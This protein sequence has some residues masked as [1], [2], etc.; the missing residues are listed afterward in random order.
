[1]NTDA[2]EFTP[3]NSIAENVNFTATTEQD[4][5]K[6]RILIALICVMASQLL[7]FQHR[8]EQV[9]EQA[10]GHEE[11]QN[12]F[13]SHMASSDP[14]AAARV[15]NREPEQDDCCDE[16]DHIPHHALPQKA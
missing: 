13:P 5:G 3:L 10:Q 16:K 6:T 15:E 2:E 9:P 11:P 12:V 4:A 7:G 1:M 14:I 8:E